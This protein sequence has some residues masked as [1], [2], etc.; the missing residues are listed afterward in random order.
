MG[1]VPPTFVTPKAGVGPADD[2]LLDPATPAEREERKQAEQRRWAHVW[3][4]DAF[5]AWRE[6]TTMP[7][8]II[9][10]ADVA[11]QRDLTDAEVDDYYAAWRDHQTSQALWRPQQLDE[12]EEE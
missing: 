11:R 7:A 8:R 6:R 9:E 2:N 12:P 10:L 4:R 1:R 5:P 3:L